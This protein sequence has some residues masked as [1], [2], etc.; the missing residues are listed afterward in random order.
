MRATRLKDGEPYVKSIQYD[1][2]TYLYVEIYTDDDGAS[3]NG[4]HARVGR[5]YGDR[6]A[7]KALDP[8]E[9]DLYPFVL[10]NEPDPFDLACE[11]RHDAD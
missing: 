11:R 7:C 8:R 9:V 4:E 2:T 1:E 3:G 10:T 5:W 6:A